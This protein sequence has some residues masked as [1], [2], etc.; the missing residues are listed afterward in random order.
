MKAFGILALFFA[1][2]LTALP[3][4]ADDYVSGYTRSNGTYVA[5]HH[6]SAADSSFNN[7]WSTQGNTNPYTGQA[8]TKTPSYGASA[9]SY[10]N[11]SNYGGY[12]SY[13]APSAGAS[14]QYSG[15]GKR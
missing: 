3:A 2:S 1:S 7:N 5:P 11:T 9:N 8:G 14:Y 10:G 4:S 15:Y 6:R 12:K 13:S